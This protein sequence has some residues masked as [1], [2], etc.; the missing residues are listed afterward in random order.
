MILT[1]LA[2]P[3]GASLLSMGS[4]C[5]LIISVDSKVGRMGIYEA[6]QSSPNWIMNSPRE[7][8]QLK[9]KLGRR[10]QLSCSGYLSYTRLNTVCGMCTTAG[11]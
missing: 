2:M 1:R 6:L 3:Y 7:K 5:L 10:G 11:N 9:G 8:C 4:C